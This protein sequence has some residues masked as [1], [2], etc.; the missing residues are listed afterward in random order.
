M[1]KIDLND[2]PLMRQLLAEGIS[3]A[4]VARKFDLWGYTLQLREALGLPKRKQYLKTLTIE[5]EA[6]L[7][8]KIIM[9][10]TRP[11]ANKLRQLLAVE[12]KLDFRAVPMQP[13]IER[14]FIIPAAP[15]ILPAKP[16]PDNSR[17]FTQEDRDRFIRLREDNINMEM[18]A[19]VELYTQLT[20]SL[21]G[22]SLANY[23]IREDQKRKARISKKAFAFSSAHV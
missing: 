10:L 7:R 13:M 21:I 11:K 18:S 6:W 4:D 22:E 23:W 9:M 17:A 14:Y 15:P 16:E 12:F 19:V 5:Q 8:R 3:L 20:G 2:L 1:P